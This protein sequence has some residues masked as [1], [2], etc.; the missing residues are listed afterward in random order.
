MRDL[1]GE[2]RPPRLEEISVDAEFEQLKKARLI[3][4]YTWDESL[5]IAAFLMN[6]PSIAGQDASPFDP[7]AKRT[8]HFAV[9]NGCGASWLV[10]WTPLIATQPVDLW[11]MLAAGD[12][13]R[14]GLR[15]LNDLAVERAGRNAAIRVVACGP[16]GFR[17]YPEYVRRA[18][19]AFLWHY[20][21]V[22]QQHDA[23]CLGMTADGAPLHPLARGKFAI[24]NDTALRKWVPTWGEGAPWGVS[25]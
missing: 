14:W 10:N 22:E 21:P 18:L 11:R 23:M 25:A 12:F 20:P 15:R 24:P 1:F 17:R 16:E 7:T 3:L 4:R 2:P 5:P 8:I 19:Q 9:R 6:N 13:E